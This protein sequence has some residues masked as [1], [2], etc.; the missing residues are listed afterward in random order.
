M[1]SIAVICIEELGRRLSTVYSFH[2]LPRCSTTIDYISDK[3]SYP[4]STVWRLSIII[5]L[6]VRKEKE[7][8]PPKTTTKTSQN[9]N[10]A[11]WES[12]QTT[13]STPQVKFEAS[14]AESL[15]SVPGDMYPSLFS[16]PA[17]LNPL[18]SV[19]TPQSFSGD[20]D[21]ASQPATSHPTPSPAPEGS[22]KKPVKKRKSWGQVLPE[23]KTNL[24]PRYDCLLMHL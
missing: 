6:A 9:T 8:S 5:S 22:E 11:T 12:Q 3:A 14:P 23:P 21:L 16:T 7:P 19:M 20:G 4:E 13:T 1:K 10:M 18:E 2:S 17:T 24:P 15:M